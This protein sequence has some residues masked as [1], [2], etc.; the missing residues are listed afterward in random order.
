MLFKDLK[1]VLE[2]LLCPQTFIN[3][4]LC[5]GIGFP[6]FKLIIFPFVSILVHFISTNAPILCFFL[7]DNE[8]KEKKRNVLPVGF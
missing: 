5:I 3:I 2:P 6:F 7:H 4:I 1:G 8:S